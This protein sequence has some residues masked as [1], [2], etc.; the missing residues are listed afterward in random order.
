MAS[1]MPPGIYGL[2]QTKR[3][4]KQIDPE[5]RKEMDK[6]LRA[7]AMPVVMR[8]R[9]YVPN[10]PPL[11]RWN[12]TIAK[13][14]SRPSY[15]P[16]G[17]I[18]DYS[19]GEWDSDVVR[20]GIVVRQGSRKRRGQVE[21]VAWSIQNRSIAGAIF[22]MMGKGISNVYMVRNVRR[23]WGMASRLIW[24]AWDREGGEAKIS[25]KMVATIRQ[26]EIILH[27]KMESAAKKG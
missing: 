13:P 9:S 2:Q 21:R 14:G 17:R 22:E 11:S 27:R 20:K 26:Y 24:K 16:Y 18:R 10:E 8:A 15:S 12:Q 1:K 7:I 25:N 23:R 6:T 4:L 5:V 19:R 3:L